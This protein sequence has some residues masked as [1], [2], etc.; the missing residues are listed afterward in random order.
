MKAVVWTDTFQVIVLYTAMVAVL[1]KGTVD[2]GGFSV[3]WERN[4]E[5]SRT[6]LFK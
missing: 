4:A 5:G 3:V 1:V 6:T 2:M